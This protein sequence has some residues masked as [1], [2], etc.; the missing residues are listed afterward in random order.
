MC[1]AEWW[2]CQ[3][4]WVTPNHHNSSHFLWLTISSPS[5]WK[6]NHPWMGVVKITWSVFEFWGL[7]HVSRM[8]EAGV[9]RFY[10]QVGHMKSL[11]LGYHGTPEWIGMHQKLLQ[12]SET[13]PVTS[14]MAVTDMLLWPL[15]NPVLLATMVCNP[16]IPVSSLNT[17]SLILND[18]CT[19]GVEVE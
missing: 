12:V 1:S 15:Y 6:A 19:G 2:R 8:T 16:F 18:K 5:L 3:C 9:V 4:P 7:N 13:W 17:I 11:A 10:I 14:Y